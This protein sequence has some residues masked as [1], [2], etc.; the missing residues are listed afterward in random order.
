MERPL[1]SAAKFALICGTAATIGLFYLFAACTLLGLLVWIGLE[2]LIAVLVARF[3]GLGFMLKYIER[4]LTLLRLVAGSLWLRRGTTYRLKLKPEEA[5]GIMAIMKNLC[6]WLQIPLPD[7][8][9]LEMN[10]GAWVELKGLR[11]NLGRTHLGI[12]YDLLA[13]LTEEEVEAVLAHELVH[14]KLIHRAFRNWLRAG[15]NRTAALSNQLSAVAQAYRRAK[16]SFS[17]VELILRV[18]DGLTRLAARL[19]AAY[20]RQDEF[21]ADHGAAELCGS[22]PLRS[23]LQKLGPLSAVLARLPWNER[24]AQI[25]SEEGLSGWL[26]T[27][28]SAAVP[29]EGPGGEPEIFNKYSTH[30]AT[31]DRLAA[32]PDDGSQLLGSGPGI[33]LLADPDAVARELVAEIERTLQAAE[34]EDLK[35]LRRWLRKTRRGARIRPAQWP[36]VLLVITGIVLSLAALLNGQWVAAVLCL[37]VF[38]PLGM[39]LF[40]V[41]RPRD[42]Q[43]LPVPS[44]ALLW[45]EPSPIKDL[46][47]MQQ[48]L[49][50]ELRGKVAVEKNARRRSVACARE[51]YQALGQCDYLRAHVAARLCVEFDKKSIEGTVAMAIAAA[52]FNQGDSNNAALQRLL[53]HTGFR[54]PSTAWGAAWALVLAGAWMPAEALLQERLKKNPDDPT[55]LAMLALCQS[56]R[57]KLQSALAHIRK[58]CTPEPPS[59]EH[60]KLLIRLLLD[61]GELDEAGQWLQ[62]METAVPGDRQLMFSLIRLHLLRRQFPLAEEWLG[63]LTAKADL[64]PH[65]FVQLGGIYEQAREDAKACELYRRALAGGHFPEALLGLARQAA[66]CGDKMSAKQHIFAALDVTKPL[67]EKALSAYDLFQGALALLLSL[68]EPATDCSA[69]IAGFRPSKNAGPLNRRSLLVY[70]RNEK[71]AEAHLWALIQAMEPG[72]LP[73]AGTYFNISKAPRDLQPAHPVRPGV[74]HVYQ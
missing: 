37:A 6:G 35:Q 27:Q 43:P 58:T 24:V 33:H 18:S 66:H 20:S 29:A 30:P 48:Q 22:A 8:V 61:H 72:K 25:R 26:A 70:A 23:S 7:A 69:W 68:E 42:R 73:M 11:R 32:L 36:G 64:P 57:G 74:Q 12:G 21:E 4:D 67:G 46:K 14:A 10:A 38:I 56:H 31:R 47:E 44:F 15:L 63:Y 62:E 17:G 40:R 1:G 19:V 13:G 9:F 39:V 28:L 65:L 59:A 16:K 52:A 49:E 53:R 34:K 5:P 50:K 60:V 3:G 2:L 51:A 55:F 54:S 45:A 71:E 41:I